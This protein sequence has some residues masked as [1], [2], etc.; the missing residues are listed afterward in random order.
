MP[1]TPLPD[2]LDKIVKDHDRRLHTLETAAPQRFTSMSAGTYTVTD[3]SGVTRVQ[4]GLLDDGTYGVGVLDDTGILVSL[5]ALVFG[6]EAEEVA[7]TEATSSTSYVDLST[8]GPSVD[9]TVGPSGRVLIDQSAFIGL[10]TG[11]MTAYAGTHIDGVLGPGVLGLSTQTADP[12]A[13]T[14]S[15]RRLVTGLT[16]GVHTFTMKYKVTS[17][18]ANYSNRVLTVQPL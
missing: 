1:E 14:V 4:F 13:T 15:G 10:S 11:A 9:V 8:V 2:G 18:S 16:P 3:D 17:D 12:I 6:V 5:N 7:A